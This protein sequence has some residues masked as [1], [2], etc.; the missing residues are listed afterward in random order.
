MNETETAMNE[1]ETAMNERRNARGGQTAAVMR[2]N[3][4]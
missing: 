2:R 4:Q 1:T 3:V